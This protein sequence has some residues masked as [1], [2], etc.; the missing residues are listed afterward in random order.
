MIAYLQVKWSQDQQSLV[1]NQRI[2]E[3]G[4][5]V[6]QMA[7]SSKQ[8]DLVQLPESCEELQIMVLIEPRY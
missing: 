7:R 8:N 4:C 2:T 6:L 3:N 5:N 1:F